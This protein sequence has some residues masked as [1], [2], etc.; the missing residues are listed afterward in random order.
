MTQEESIKS[1]IEEMKKQR[2]MSK[3][4][5]IFVEYYL[6]LIWTSGFDEGRKQLSHRK[7]IVQKKDGQIIQPWESVN[8]AARAVGVAP[9]SIS[10]V[11]NKKYGHKTCAGFEWEYL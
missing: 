2:P 6:Q 4:L 11:L 7:P 10:Q 1:I 8:L 3:D 9:T 5:V